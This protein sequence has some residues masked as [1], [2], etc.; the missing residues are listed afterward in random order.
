MK[1]EL[2]E[3]QTS[4][5]TNFLSEEVVEGSQYYIAMT[6]ALKR[7]IELFES[8]TFGELYD[9]LILLNDSVNTYYSK[10]EGLELSKEYDYVRSRLDTASTAQVILPDMLQY[11][12][13]LKAQYP[14]LYSKEN[15]VK[16]S[17]YK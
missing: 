13:E 10:R 2:Q 14:D 8:G 4:P 15:P 16:V 17:D 6:S 11:M 9:S 12:K 1:E 7:C 3:T 5:D